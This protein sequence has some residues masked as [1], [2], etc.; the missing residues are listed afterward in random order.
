MEPGQTAFQVNMLTI[1]SLFFFKTDSVPVESVVQNGG[2]Y[3]LQYHEERKTLQTEL[4]STHQGSWAAESCTADRWCLCAVWGG[5]WP[6]WRPQCMAGN[7]ADRA[8]GMEPN[9]PAHSTLLPQDLAHHKVSLNH[10]DSVL[11][12]CMCVCV[13]VCVCV[14]V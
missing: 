14:W 1:A 5:R 13:C 9:I 8:P 7:P 2:M 11:H 6:V 10:R 12:I 4:S 3:T